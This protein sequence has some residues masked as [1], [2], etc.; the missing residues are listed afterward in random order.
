MQVSI[1]SINIELQD[2]CRICAHQSKGGFEVQTGA[3]WSEITQTGNPIVVDVGAYTGPYAISA[4][5]QGCRVFAYEP[6]L[7]PYR[8]L[9]E[10]ATANGATVHAQRFGCLDVDA[11]LPLHICGSFPLSSAS[12]FAKDRRHDAEATARTV[13]LDSERMM[14]PGKVRIMKIDVEG[15][16]DRV[17]RG[18]RKILETDRPVV[19]VEAL[20][21]A[22]V[23]KILPHL[24]MYKL[25]RVLD[26]RNY[27]YVPA[28][29]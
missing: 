17:L 18:A 29:E 22:A 7:A 21:S 14:Y 19:I 12:S 3:L 8:R 6:S 5:K 11:M 10:N 1:G 13:T 28:A 20:D 2:G 24:P 25:S 16:E 15:T 27:F 26:G 23:Q 4:A 9:V